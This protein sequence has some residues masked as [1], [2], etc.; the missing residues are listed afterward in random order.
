MGS[1]RHWLGV[2][3]VVA[4]SLGVA[5][6]GIVVVQATGVADL[7]AFFGTNGP[8]QSFSTPP[9]PHALQLFQTTTLPNGETL[10]A[11]VARVGNAEI[12]SAAFAHQVA[13]ISDNVGSQSPP[14]TKGQIWRKALNN[15]VQDASLYERARVEGITVS[16][17]EVA[18]YIADQRAGLARSVQADPS[19]TAR[20]NAAIVAAGDSD[21]DSFF[22]DPKIVQSY[23]RDL[24]KGKLVGAH[25]GKNSTAEAI[26]QFIQQT[27]SQAKVQVFIVLPS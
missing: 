14:L 18:S 22:Q 4:L 24:M 5:L 16:D 10:P 25:L 17:S 1:V 3:S 11:V 12:T 27:I 7:N 8:S 13:L 6:T 23:R 19:V 21:Q 20:I 26:D 9:D 15:L 2:R